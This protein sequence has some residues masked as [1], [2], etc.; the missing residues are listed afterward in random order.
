MTQFVRVIL[1]VIIIPEPQEG[2]QEGTEAGDEDHQR[3]TLWNE[4]SMQCSFDE[5]S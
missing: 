2:T 1:R 4:G 5:A 3:Q